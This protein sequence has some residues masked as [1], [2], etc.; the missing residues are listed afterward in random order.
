MNLQQR[1][2]PVQRNNNGATMLKDGISGD[3]APHTHTWDRSAIQAPG[4]IRHGSCG[5]P[6]MSSL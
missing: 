2:D 3:I 6:A 4:S 1:K 5:D